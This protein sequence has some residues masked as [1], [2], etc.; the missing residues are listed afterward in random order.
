M[1]WRK[2]SWR[3]R[4]HTASSASRGKVGQSDPQ[5]A[6]LSICRNLAM[7]QELGAYSAQMK[8]L[9]RDIRGLKQSAEVRPISLQSG[10][11]A[12]LGLRCV[13]ECT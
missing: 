1:H 4:L 7:L 3:A 6:G 11:G 10:L 12:G 5:A 8:K 9:E 2:G 13:C